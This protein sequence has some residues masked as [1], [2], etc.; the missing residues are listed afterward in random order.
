MGGKNGKVSLDDTL[1]NLRFASK[2]MEREAQRSEREEKKEKDKVKRALEKGMVDNARI[3]GENAIRKHNE[4]L[5]YLRLASKLDAVAS[6]IQSATRTQE[7]SKQFGSMVPQ[8]NAA[9][10][11]MDIHKISTTMDQFERVFENIDV[12]TGT[13]NESL[14]SA[15]AYTAPVSQ[16]DQLLGQIAN[17]H[18]I[19]VQAQLGEVTF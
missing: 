14:N 6:K 10:K 17:E 12:A 11:N 7:L 8:I 16:V 3:Y 1:F 5:N 13:I 19:E 18:N 4:S 15:T 2:Q 9:L